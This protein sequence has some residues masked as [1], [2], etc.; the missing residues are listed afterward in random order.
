MS[1][2]SVKPWNSDSQH[3]GCRSLPGWLLFLR[4]LGG[5]SD[6]ASTKAP[7]NMAGWMWKV[8]IS[9][10]RH[11]TVYKRSFFFILLWV[12]ARMWQWWWNSGNRFF[13]SDYIEVSM[14][15]DI[16]FSN[17]RLEDVVSG[18]ESH[19][20]A[21]SSSSIH[22]FPSGWV[23]PS[24]LTHCS[25]QR[26]RATP[27]VLGRGPRTSCHTWPED[28]HF[29]LCCSGLGRWNLRLAANFARF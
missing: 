12:A 20:L 6:P 21:W 11:R 2:C 16:K 9:R 17:R 25:P 8:R 10:K 3:L 7:N 1:W 19:Q 22:L 29:T 24:L 27:R 18:V 26:P 13:L 15:S 23:C 14:V 28:T 4:A 5:F